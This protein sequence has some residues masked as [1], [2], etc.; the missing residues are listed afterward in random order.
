VHEEQAV[1]V[2]HR[3]NPAGIFGPVLGRDFSS[4]IELVTRLMNTHANVTNLPLAMSTR[5]SLAAT[6]VLAPL[7][8]W[9][10]V[11]VTPPRTATLP[12]W[13]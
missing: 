13:T 7:E 11:P 5:A 8:N 3:L 9:Y 10:S 4:S 2:L 12:S 1:F 6:G